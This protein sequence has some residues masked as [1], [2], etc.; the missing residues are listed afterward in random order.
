M[1][2]SLSQDGTTPLIAAVRRGA[3]AVVKMLLAAGANVNLELPVR[4]RL[5]PNA[6]P[7]LHVAR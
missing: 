4:R 7:L 3:D 5:I 1:H 6:V 2:A